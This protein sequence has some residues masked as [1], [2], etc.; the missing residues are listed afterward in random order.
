VPALIKDKFTAI[1]AKAEK[2][3]GAGVDEKAK[4]D[5]FDK[6]DKIIKAATKADNGVT[7]ALSLDWQL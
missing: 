6:L 3:I 5:F 2:E 7:K 1:K 4:A